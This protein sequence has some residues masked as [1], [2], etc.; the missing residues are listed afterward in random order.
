MLTFRKGGRYL[1]TMKIN[2]YYQATTN[3]TV[4]GTELLGDV[5]A[6]ICIIGSGPAAISMALSLDASPLTVIL[7]TGGSWSETIA[8]QDPS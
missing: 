7:L 3:R 2:S 4:T 6:D 8:N 5:V 1:T